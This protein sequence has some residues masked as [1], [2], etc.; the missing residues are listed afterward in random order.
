MVAI[1]NPVMSGLGASFDGRFRA[2]L[3]T[4][5]RDYLCGCY[6]H[7]FTCLRVQTLHTEGCFLSVELFAPMK[8][9]EGE[10][11]IETV[12]LV[13]LNELTALQRFTVQKRTVLPVPLLLLLPLI[14]P[15]LLLLLLLTPLIIV[16]KAEQFIIHHRLQ[17]HHWKSWEPFIFVMIHHD[18]VV[19]AADLGR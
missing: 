17:T 4:W 11:Q 5:V 7:Y 6:L 1:F 16:R 14:S 2:I 18:W 12:T 8:G 10:T 15:L 13:C 3:S 19:I 9:N